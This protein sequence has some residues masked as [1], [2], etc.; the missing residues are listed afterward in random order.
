MLI[1]A[2]VKCYY[3]GFVSGQIEGDPDR[4]RPHWYFRVRA[5]AAPPAESN[6]RQIRCI[7]CGGPV[8]LDDIEKVRAP[9]RAAQ[10]ALATAVG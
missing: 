2:D 9:G 8:F 6:L 3:C 4:A 5:D 10:P 7:R 1:R